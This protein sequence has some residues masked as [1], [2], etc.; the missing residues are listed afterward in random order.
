M[1]KGINIK[2]KKNS[3]LWNFYFKMRLGRRHRHPQFHLHPQYHQTE[4]F[5]F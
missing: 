4:Y 2:F 1:Y 3:K 5:N